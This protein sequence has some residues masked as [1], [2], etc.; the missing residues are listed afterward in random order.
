MRSVAGDLTAYFFFL[1]VAFAF[2]L[3]TAFL[4]VAGLLGF[5]T[6][7][8][9]T[10]LIVLTATAGFAGTTGFAAATG[11]AGTAGF[12]AG[13]DFPLFGA[14]GATAP[15]GAATTFPFPLTPGF[16]L[17]AATGRTTTA[18]ALAP[19]PRFAGGGGGGGGGGGARGF[20]NLRVSV[21][22]RSL[23]SNKSKNTSFA[24][25][26]YV[27]TCGVKRSSV[28]SGNRIFCCTCRHL[29]KKVFIFSGT[30]C[31]PA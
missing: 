6:A 30:A 10:G 21:R 13:A 27:A 2:A 26:G 22:R 3:T 7:G 12:A 14:I 29:A 9:L 5:L 24:I 20:R 28:I 15:A 4:P 16:P 11:F 17:A 19:R 18:A 23:P 8:T 1:E 31:S 25:F